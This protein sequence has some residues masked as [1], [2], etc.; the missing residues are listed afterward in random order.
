MMSL[1]NTLFGEAENGNGGK[2]RTLCPFH[3][4]KRVYTDTSSLETH[5]KDHEIPAESLPGKVFL[6]SSIGCGGSFPNML[7]LMEHMRQHHKPNI[8]FLCENCRTKLRTYKGL[9]THLHTC[10]KV[11]QGKTKL[12]EPMPPPPAAAAPTDP[13]MTPT[14]MDQDPPQLESVS[15]SQQLQIQNTDGSLPA[16]VPQSES[17]APPHL[18]PP[19]LPNPD[20]SPPQLA[21]QQL[22]EAALLPQL[23]N[24]ASDM[25]PSLN[26]EGTSVVPD[27][28]DT[29]GQNQAPSGSLEPT[30]PA[31]GSSPLSPPPSAVWRKNQAQTS[32]RRVLWEHTRGRYTCLQ[33]GHTVTNR[34]DMSQHISAQHSGNKPAEDTESSAATS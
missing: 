33:C 30:Q 24:E 14:A 2:Q 19:F 11:S 8:Y 31:S 15:S 23:I 7:K 34:K 29:R 22:T 6:C 3:G 1:G 9:L 18:G 20:P 26:L 10:S 32:S 13:S 27:A 4:C 17:A 21:A 16:A 5:I 12:P 25:P 28:P